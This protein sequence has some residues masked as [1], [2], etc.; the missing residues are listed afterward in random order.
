MNQ[1]PEIASGA[2]SYG[3]GLPDYGLSLSAIHPSRKMTARLWALTIGFV[4]IG[5]LCMTRSFAYLGI[6]SL[7]LFVGE[8]VLGLFLL[9]KSSD[10]LGRWFGAMASGARL[11]PLAWSFYLFVGYGVMETLRGII[12]GYPTFTTFQILV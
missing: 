6:K 9:T 10:V 1:I 5:Y 4:A 3:H 8:A 11:S 12:A 2:G 7:N